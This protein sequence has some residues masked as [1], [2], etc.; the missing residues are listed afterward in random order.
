[1]LH[2]LELQDTQ[3]ADQS[4]Q[5]VRDR[6]IVIDRGTSETG[7]LRELLEMLTQSPAIEPRPEAFELAADAAP[8]A[9]APKRRK[10]A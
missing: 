6:N 7:G 2:V 8:V 3:Q 4:S 10:K 5:N 9:K 1:M